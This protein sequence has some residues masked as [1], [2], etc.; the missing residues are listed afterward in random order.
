MAE[1]ENPYERFKYQELVLRDELAID[2]TVLANE[3]TFL[4]YL[5]TSLSFAVVGGTILKFSDSPDLRVVGVIF[6]FLAGGSL[7]FG[8]WRSLTMRRRIRGCRQ[9]VDEEAKQQKIS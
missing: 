3:R 6:L 5:R 4:S 2:R 7:G 9:L 8:I 1:G